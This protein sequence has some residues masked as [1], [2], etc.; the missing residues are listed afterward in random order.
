MNGFSHIEIMAF[1]LSLGVLLATARF[2]GEIAKHFQQPAVVGEILA[3]ILLGHTIL[4]RA[5]PEIFQF[6]F[7]ETGSTAQ[8]FNGLML[9]SGILFLL[10]AGMEF[11]LSIIWRQG[12]SILGVGIFGMLVPFVVGF[13]LA[14]FFPDLLGYHPGPSHFVF[15]LFFATALS[16]SALPVI[17]KT[18]LDLNLYHTDTGLVIVASAILQDIVGWII[19]S[20]VLGLMGQTK[21]F[22]PAE[23]LALTLL[24]T[25]FMLTVC[26]K[27]VHRLL[28]W[29]QAHSTW[30]GGVLGFS[31]SLAFFGAAF[32]EWIGIH[33]IFGAF[34]VGVALGDSTHLREQSRSAM[35]RFISYIF[36]PLFF[37]NIGLRVDFMTN[38]DLRL[39]VLVFVLACFVKIS[40]C[41]L[42]ARFSGIESREAWVIA[43]GMNARGAMEIILGALALQY[44]VIHESLF[45]SLVIMALATSLMSGPLI[46]KI[47]RQKNPV[48][49][50]KFVSPKTFIPVFEAHNVQEA[51]QKLSLSLCQGTSLNPSK[52]FETLWSREQ[53]FST[54]LPG[55]M[56]IPHA[57][58]EGLTSARLAIAISPEGVD[59][60]ASDGK[61]SHLICLILTPQQDHGLQLDIL[62]D[63]SK[64]FITQDSVPQILRVKNFTEFLAFV[65]GKK[66][67][68]K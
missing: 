33:A 64:T 55:G 26:R 18:L 48:S 58:L 13:T 34:L 22:T 9:L 20:I 41:L 28:P 38:F 16:I 19:F 54:G 39:T 32:T 3:G 60:N 65:K 7:P 30:A 40:G 8:A 12:R 27:W 49:F 56:A 57:R 52:V 67:G 66:A 37:A 43:V 17:A 63:I 46:K 44:G 68:E 45:V 5:F 61:A 31:L 23:T 11:N 1:L 2:F 47:L 6:L 4:G 21:F 14:H 24:Y 51:I 29:I 25:V 10:V 42:G 59:F 53:T 15:E 35:E 50:T 36:V 62:A